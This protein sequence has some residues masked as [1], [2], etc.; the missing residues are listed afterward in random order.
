MDPASAVVGKVLGNSAFIRVAADACGEISRFQPLERIAAGKVRSLTLWLVVLVVL[1][2]AVLTTSPARAESYDYAPAAGGSLCL[3]LVSTSFEFVPSASYTTSRGSS[4]SLTNRANAYATFSVPAGVTYS[5]AVLAFDMVSSTG[6]GGISV[7]RFVGS[8]AADQQSWDDL[9]LSPSMASVTPAVGAKELVLPGVF[10]D[11]MN[12]LSA[13]GGGLMTIALRGSNGGNGFAF[14]M[15]NFRLSGDTVVVPTV[16]SVA[17]LAGIVG[18]NVRLSGTGFSGADSVTF[19][20]ATATFSIDDDSSITATVP[21]LAPGLVNIQVSTAAGGSSTAG[22]GDN[23]TVLRTLAGPVL[24]AP[25]DGA[26]VR[27]PVFRGVAAPSARVVVSWGSGAVE[28]VADSTGA[29]LIPFALGSFPDGVHDFEIYQLD[30]D[31]NASPRTPVTL[32]IDSEAP[33]A[34]VISSPAGGGILATDRPQVEGTAEA[35]STVT[36]LV[37]GA[38]AG[39]TTADESGVWSLVTPA[40]AAGAHTVTATAAD[41]AGNVSAASAAIPF[42]VD[43]DSP[44]MPTLTSPAEGSVLTDRTPEVTGAAEPGALVRVILDGATAG[45][46]TADGAG[47]WAVSVSAPLVDG[48]HAVRATATDAAG[49]TSPPSVVVNF[50]VDATAPAAP[51]ITSPTDG[52][53]VSETE[54]TLS[55]TAEA[56]ATVAIIID[57]VA[58]GAATAD[59]S[60]E[61]R[62]NPP[63]LADGAHTVRATAQDEAGNLSVSSATINFTVDSA[64][65]VAPVIASPAQGAT[66]STASPTVSGTAE[67]G[68]TVTVTIDGAVAGTTTAAGSGAWTFAASALTD[69]AHSVSATATDGAGNVSPA[70]SSITFTVDAA[71]PASA[72]ITAPA[73]GAV[74]GD[75]TVVVR[76][77]AEPDAQVDVSLDGTA[78]GTVTADGSGAWSLD[79]GTPTPGGHTIQVV[80][81]DAAGNA[82]AATETAFTYSVLQVEDGALPAGQVAV[83]Y[84]AAITPQAGSAPFTFELASGELPAGLML[85][86]GGVI[87]GVPTEGGSFNLSIR[88]TDASGGAG[89]SAAFTL[90]IAAPDLVITP[91]ALPQ[92]QFQTPYTQALSASGGVTPYSD[93][94]VTD[95]AL[96]TG[97]TL[98]SSGMISGTPQA[99]GEFDFMVAVTDAATGEGPYDATA[100]FTLVVQAPATPT[101]QDASVAVPYGSS[102]TEITLTAGGLYERF[103][104]VTQP[105]NGTVSLAGDIATYTPQPDFFGQDSFTVMAV[106]PGGDSAPATVT[107]TVAAPPPPEVTPSDP[108]D[109]PATTGP[110][111]VASVALGDQVQ[112]VVD[113]FRIVEQARNGEA[114]IESG[115]VSTARVSSGAASSAVRYSLVYRPRPDFMGVDEVSVV[116][117]GPGGDSAPAVFTFHAPGRAPDLEADMLADGSLVFEPTADLVGGPFQGLRIV[118]P[119]AFGEA[120]VQG[121]TLTFTPGE[122]NAGATFLE[123]VIELPFGDSA[124]GRIDLVALAV[125]ETQALTAQTL[126][127]VPVTVRITDDVRGGPFT[128]AAVVSV[129]PVEAG[130]ATIRAAG[131]GVYDL[132]YAP[133]GAFSGEAVVTFTLGNGVSTATSTLT[134]TVEPRPDPSLDPDVRGLAGSQ[135]TTARR[136]ADAQI[137]NFQRRLETLRHGDNPSSN[138]VTLNVGFGRNTAEQDPRV[139]LAR[140]LRAPELDPGVRYDPEREFMGQNLWAGRQGANK[141]AAGDTPGG[142]PA[143]LQTQSN[144]GAEEGG[145]S[146]GVWTAGSI[147]WGRQNADGQRD[148]RFRTQGLTIGVDAQ[149]TDRL[150]VGGGVGYGRDRSEIGEN[151]TLSRARSLTGAVYGSWRITDAVFLDGVAGHGD[152]AF[153]SRR[154]TEGLS[155]EPDAFAL[156]ERDGSVRFVSGTIGRT[157]GEGSLRRSLY[158][159]MDARTIELDAFTETGAGLASLSW[160]ALEQDSLSASVGVAWSWR[161][162]MGERGGLSPYARLEWS[163]ELERLDE[164]GVRYADWV[165][166]P[167]YG[168][169]MDAWSRDSLSLNLGAEWTLR[170][171]LML[172]AGYRGHLGDASQSHGGEFSLRWS[173]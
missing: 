136:F 110:G 46:A 5:D 104:I 18:S 26:S 99:F 167:T 120:Q 65:P 79:A 101:A 108:V 27:F 137:N 168:V 152:L 31:A 62:F 54:P 105:G 114:S 39:V 13:S 116:A 98:S 14:Q 156:G 173:W 29:F 103:E 117:F 155:D 75:P 158:L 130:E 106:G 134:I 119:P 90:L 60:G 89:T 170:D 16:S 86:D 138:G 102:G 112:G 135:V 20:G 17:P 61:W 169:P 87:E 142:A 67:P 109:V 56:G 97:V 128:E 38:A 125:V 144:T 57:G 153:D 52:A 100:S 25:A 9:R 21:S 139:E 36:V 123:Y 162:D 160:E 6:S 7:G 154:W 47:E 63:V 159:R 165:A 115:R 91:A 80:V 2:A 124:P 121:L 28:D 78:I 51:V 140:Q 41:A 131:S 150:I 3:C 94:R 45:T 145:P 77:T 71:A 50:V 4:A 161:I 8:V 10:V 48:A 70:S 68:V 132:T 96:P 49:N 12:A 66:T 40:L 147:D 76:G 58:A 122:E 151:G 73:D 149:L 1:G 129:S 92:G 72:T 37:D 69:G 95:G 118:T 133:Q 30:Q 55:G 141:D 35:G 15:D 22:S 126:A 44:A 107:I 171:R 81:R 113:G 111:G 23:F 84:E 74:V 148:Q 53:A 59:G 33:V 163:R 19:A 164:Q 11:E 42:I 172:S 166:G 88:V 82:S 64:A 24:E 143:G 43:A 157:A 34:P 83:P 127:G 32:T 93:W 146:V 85:I